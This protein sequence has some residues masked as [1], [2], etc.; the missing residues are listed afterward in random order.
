MSNGKYLLQYIL[1]SLECCLIPFLCDK[2]GISLGGE[3]QEFLPWRACML[4]TCHQSEHKQPLFFGIDH[5]KFEVLF[6]CSCGI[7]PFCFMCC[8]WNVYLSNFFFKLD[9]VHF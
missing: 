9:F 2:N 4:G 5:S 3:Y 7:F 8:L 6:S 1:F